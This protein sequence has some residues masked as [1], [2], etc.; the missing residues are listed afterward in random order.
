MFLQQNKYCWRKEQFAA[1]Q[2]KR[3]LIHRFSQNDIQLSFLLF[4]RCRPLIS[5]AHLPPAIKSVI[6]T[7]EETIPIIVEFT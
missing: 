2:V 5:T 6:M 3:A 1:D 4:K 7:S